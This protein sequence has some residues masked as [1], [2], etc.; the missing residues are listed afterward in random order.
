M[1][2]S[3][4][5]NIII[6]ILAIANLCLLGAIGWQV[7]E[8]RTARE[9]TAAELTERFARQNVD[10]T[11]QLPEQTPPAGMTLTRSTDHDAAL[12]QALLGE[13]AAARDLGGGIYRYSSDTGRGAFRSG[14]SFEVTGR[15][16]SGDAESFCRKLCRQ[17]GY[18]EFTMELDETGTGTGSALQYFNGLP[19]IH[20]EVRFSVEEGILTAVQGVA[21]PNDASPAEDS[22][23]MT[24]ATALTLFL[25]DCRATGAVVSAVTAI[26]PCYELQSTA[27]SPM[28]LSPAYRVTADTGF[29]YVSCSTGKVT[30]G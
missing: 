13:Q 23:T 9:R 22:D 18:E 12:A 2:R 3:R 24:A 25:E 17:F 10:L 8:E 1:D 6:L 27:S 20:A 29:F 4:L 30:R 28:T 16:G 7:T 26:V 21:L 14:G 19:V 11:A 5:K 15:L